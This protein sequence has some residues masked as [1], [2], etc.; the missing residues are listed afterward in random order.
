MKNILE[1]ANEVVNDREIDYGSVKDNFTLIAKLW[2]AFLGVPITPEQFGSLMILL[3]IGRQ[4]GGYKEDN[5]IDIA[6]YAACL[7]KL[8]KMI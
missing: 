8:N 1:K 7:E 6:G 5:L 3:K 4:E 2:S